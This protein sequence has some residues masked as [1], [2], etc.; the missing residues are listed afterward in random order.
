MI[1]LELDIQLKSNYSLEWQEQEYHEAYISHFRHEFS[2]WLQSSGINFN[3]KICS[4]IWY[5]AEQRKFYI[6]SI[7]KR[8]AQIRDAIKSDTRFSEKYFTN[9]I[10]SSADNY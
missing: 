10:I 2:K 5:L 4:D 6:N 7:S 9:T 8:E 1:L 3:M